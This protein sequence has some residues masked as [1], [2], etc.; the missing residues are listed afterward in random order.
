MAIAE[1]AAGKVKTDEPG[2][3]G[4]KNAHLALLQGQRPLSSVASSDSKAPPQC[5]FIGIFIGFPGGLGPR[6]GF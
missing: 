6:A 3:A 1:Q 2:R 5:I 4:D